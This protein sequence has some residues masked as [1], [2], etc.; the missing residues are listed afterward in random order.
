MLGFQNY[1]PEALLRAEDRSMEMERPTEGSRSSEESLAPGSMLLERTLDRL[2]LFFRV[3]KKES[4]LRRTPLL[5]PRSMGQSMQ[6]F[7]IESFIS[8]P[9]IHL[10]S[11]SKC[12]S[13]GGSSWY[14][15]ESKKYSYLPLSPLGTRL[16]THCSLLKNGW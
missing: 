9:S 8:F 11:S 10:T 1:L 7:T 6:T 12:A 13:V 4:L 15:Q 16:K 5:L 2:N 3:P 14:V